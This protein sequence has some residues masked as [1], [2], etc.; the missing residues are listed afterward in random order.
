MRILKVLA[1]VLGALGLAPGAW[2]LDAN[3][4]RGGWETTGGGAPHIYEFTIRG[5]HVAGVYCT[6]CDDGETLAFVDGTLGPHAMAFVVNHVRDDGSTAYQ[7]HVSARIEG[8]HLAVSGVAGGPGGGNFQWIMRKDQRGPAPFGGVKVAEALPQPGAPAVNVAAY[9][10]HGQALPPGGL[11]LA[12][13]PWQQPGPWEALT[14]ARL[15]GIWLNGTGPGKQYFII[16]RVGSGLLGLVCGPCDNPYSMVAL[17]DFVIHGDTVT[18]NISH[19][20]NGIGSLP[21]HNQIVAHLT[22]NELR[23]VSIVPDNQPRPAGPAR[24]AGGISLLGPLPLE[25]TN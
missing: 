18:F 22:K 7:D 13:P 9:G 4:V 12:R 23:L 17:T 8:D 15:Q 3:L 5:N 25:Q 1:A 14:P 11:Q 16:R 20:D 6:V 10:Q 21:F 19:E 2:A 24:P